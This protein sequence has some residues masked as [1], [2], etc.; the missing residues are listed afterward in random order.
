M[1]R[2]LLALLLLGAAGCVAGPRSTLILEAEVFDGT[3]APGRQASVRIV[4]DRIAEVGE[5]TAS[6]RDSVL[7]AR[8]LALAPGFIDTHSHAD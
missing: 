6:P 4:G 1:I 7:D 5:L 8:G 3:G 2:S